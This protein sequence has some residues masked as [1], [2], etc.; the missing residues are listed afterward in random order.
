MLT[1][2]LVLAPCPVWTPDVLVWW[3]VPVVVV[4]FVLYLGVLLYDTF[5]YNRY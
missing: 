3:Q 2:V 1:L 5:F 4:L